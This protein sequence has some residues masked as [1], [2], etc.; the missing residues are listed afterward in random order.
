MKYNEREADQSTYKTTKNIKYFIH[1][2]LRRKWPDDGHYFQREK[3]FILGIRN[4]DKIKVT[5]VHK[6][7]TTQRRHIHN[8]LPS[9]SSLPKC[10]TSQ[11]ETLLNYIFA[12][13][14]ALVGVCNTRSYLLIDIYR[15]G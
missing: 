3:H 14:S 13:K 4:I 5:S 1:L 9:T 10:K 8:P 12:S 2:S 7:Q 11:T 15:K 6:R